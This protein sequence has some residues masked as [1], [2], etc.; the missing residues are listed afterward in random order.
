MYVM[1]FSETAELAVDRET[2]MQRLLVDAATGPSRAWEPL[3]DNRG[4]V[5]H[6]QRASSKDETRVTTTETLVYLDAEPHGTRVRMEVTM[7]F[8][9]APSWALFL[10]RPLGRRRVRAAFRALLL[11]LKT[12]DVSALHEERRRA[13]MLGVR[14]RTA[15]LIF[16]LVFA[17][18]AV[19]F[20]ALVS[21]VLAVAVALF[22]ILAA[23]FPVR[24]IIRAR[25][26]INSR[27]GA[28]GSKE[29]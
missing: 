7:G 8:G 24:R 23:A 20:F 27:G 25:R 21:P 3:P 18:A 22:F 29:K 9:M 17:A 4:I 19:A 2:V 15:Q 6:T 16:Y 5:M 1:T 28:D 14:A 12:G 13:A 11:A 10:V 26:Q